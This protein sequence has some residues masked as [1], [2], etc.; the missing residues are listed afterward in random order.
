MVF[1]T[2]FSAFTFGTLARLGWWLLLDL[3][4][5]LGWH[6]WFQG[7]CQDLHLVLGLQSFCHKVDKLLGIQ[8]GINP[9]ALDNM[10]VKGVS[11]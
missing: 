8:A 4:Y 5:L 3:V 7:L 10:I 9:A 2:S 1:P 11:S 6:G